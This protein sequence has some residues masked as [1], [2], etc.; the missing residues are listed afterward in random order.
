[1]PRICV[2]AASFWALLVSSPSAFAFQEAAGP[3]YV[4]ALNAPNPSSPLAAKLPNDSGAPLRVA[5]TLVV[6]PVQVTNMLGGSITTLEQ[7]DFHLFEDDVEQPVAH[8]SRDDAPVSIGIL[9][10]SSG[11]MRNK[12]IKAEEAAA[13]FFK[14]A[15][16]NDEYFLVRFGEE[17]KLVAPF[18]PDADTILKGIHHIMPG[19]ETSLLDAIFL[20]LKEMKHARNSRKAIVIVSDGGDNWSRHTV[21]QVK[22][23]LAES[24]AQ[25]YAMGIFDRNL[26]NHPSEERRGPILL[27]QLAAQSGGRHY[28]VR[29]L[30]ELPS[31]S[32]TLSREI[33]NQYLLGYYPANGAE[34]GK[35]RRVRVKVD[36][37]GV[38]PN[39]RVYYRQ[40]YYAASR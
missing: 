25:L 33:R 13:E 31:I 26:A 32:A 28:P 22:R 16:P 36:L 38:A 18:T 10:D 29:T 20:G 5:S 2:T 27:D 7:R 34:D 30:D 11:S 15:N 9:F 1:M 40:G 35:Y 3:V 14:T 23:Q 4:R 19:G 39:L 21:G 17:A 37:P 6:I 12:M 8:F 24:E